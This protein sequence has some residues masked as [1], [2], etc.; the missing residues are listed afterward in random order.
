M[1]KGI[2][3]FNILDVKYDGDQT[4][5]VSFYNQYRTAIS[6][7]LGKSGDVIKYKDNL[8]LEEDEKM[9][10][11]LEDLLLLNVIREIDPRLPMFVRTHYNHKMK[12]DERLMDFKSDILVNIPTFIEQL[13]ANEQNNSI[14]VDDI[15]S[16]NA[17]KPRNRTKAKSAQ[18]NV[19]KNLYCRLC[20]RSNKPRDVYTSHN[21]GDE[22]CSEI[23]NQDRLRMIETLK[24]SSIQEQEP[25]FVDGDELAEMHGYSVALTDEDEVKSYS[26]DNVHLHSICPEMMLLRDVPILNLYQA[27]F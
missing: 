2:H 25:D 11:M 19:K 9:T 14:R 17:F 6:N 12:R 8:E 20:Y 7:N 10:P 24:L 21:F 15:S 22:K 18:A 16:L 1:K 4:T 5:P 27:K 3:F 26:L 23:S 13:N